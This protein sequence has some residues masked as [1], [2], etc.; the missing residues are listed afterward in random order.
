MRLASRL[1]SEAICMVMSSRKMKFPRIL[2]EDEVAAMMKSAEP[3]PRDLMMLK[4]L[5]Y[6]GLKSGEML[7]L[8]V[9]DIDFA[10]N[11]VRVAGADGRGLREVMIPGAFTFELEKYVQGRDGPVFSGRGQGN[12]LSD[13][14]IRRIVKDYARL[15]DVRN[16][17]EIR[18]HTLR[19]SYAAHLRK[20]G[21]P[22]KAI[23]GLLGHSRR[24]TTYMYTHGLSRIGKAAG[25]QEPEGDSEYGSYA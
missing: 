9:A 19:V 21:I 6:L 12:A 7:G 2:T 3:S 22:V 24:E 16:C 13:R 18:P 14:H 17:G 15:A 25:G 11:V 10:K 23:Q 1:A 8:G 4:C 20:E 5:Y